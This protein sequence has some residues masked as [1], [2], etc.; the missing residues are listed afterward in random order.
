MLKRLLLVQSWNPWQWIPR[1]KLARSSLVVMAWQAVRLLMLAAWVIVAARALG[2]DGYGTFAGV[3]GLA[4]VLA[5][6]SG[7]GIGL[8]MYQ[9][10]AI[11]PTEFGHRW[12]QTVVATLAG[13][14]VLAL[15]FVPVSQLLIGSMERGIVV[16]VAASEI[17]LFPLVGASAFAFA[18]HDRMG[19]AAALPAISAALRLLAALLF[20]DSTLSHDLGHY[21]WY[22]IVA[23]AAGSLVA[24]V[25]VHR[26]LRPGRAA[27]SIRNSDL[28][29]GFSFAIVWFTGN[30]MS[31]LDKSLV[32]R[33]GG[34]AMSGF[35]ASAYRFAS[36]LAMPVDALVMSATPRL[37][38]AGAGHATHPRLLVYLSL[39][40]ALYGAVIGACL[41]L[42]AGWLP[43]LL[44]EKFAEAVPALRWMCLF[45]P[46]YGLRQLG[47]QLLIAEGK[48][49]SRA[50]IEF[51]ALIIKVLLAHLF[52]PKWGLVGAVAALLL[53][54]GILVLVVWQ[55]VLK[56]GWR[57]PKT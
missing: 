47:G 18:A 43:W 32:L 57:Q 5:G 33:I 41:W 35:Y 49:V 48:K 30:A 46:L 9:R 19:W 2:P 42:G 23:S 38:R 15:V 37:F 51:C 12:R 16:L 14:L 21:L 4:T 40:V 22:H 34:S 10:V 8:L 17:F 31:S 25:C 50:I 3:V 44:S 20:L 45:I 39:V 55:T 26:I 7:L 29:E 11:V 52:I 28:A 53:T 54:E 24:F 36:V 56:I 13:G 6:F 27:L 1:G